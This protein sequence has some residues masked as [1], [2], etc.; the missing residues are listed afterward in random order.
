MKP[1]RIDVI[2]LL[3]LLLSLLGGCGGESENDNRPS[4]NAANSNSEKTT[5][6]KTNIEELGMLINI[7]YETDEIVWR[8]YPAQKKLVAVL[9][10]STSD[11]DKLVADSQRYR[12][13]EAVSVQCEPWFPDEL[14][15]NGGLSGDVTLKGTSYGAN[16][17][18][19][20]SFNEGRVIRIEDTNYFL[21]E[22]STK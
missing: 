14:I 4:A 8:D 7:P 12:A 18:F 16:A 19:Q 20:D 2:L 1:P 15:A 9:H 11:G 13:P 10:F 5:T 17:F 21:L 6:T 3:F 22:M